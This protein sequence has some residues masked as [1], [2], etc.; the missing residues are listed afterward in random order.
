MEYKDAL[1][2]AVK[3][4][5]NI[6]YAS[7]NGAIQI[8]KV[9]ALTTKNQ[10]DYSKPL[11]RVVKS[12]IDVNCSDGKATCYFKGKHLVGRQKYKTKGIPA[13]KVQGARKWDNKFH[14]LQ[15]S[16]VTHFENVVVLN[17]NLVVTLSLL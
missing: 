4:N 9:L 7:A 1:D 16:L 2:V 15:P 17:Q 12:C 3:V 6:V 11:P 10:S 5:D 14:K 13:L 8:G